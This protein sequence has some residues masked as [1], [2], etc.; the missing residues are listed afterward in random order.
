MTVRVVIGTILVAVTM[1][2]TSF[3]LLSEPARMADFDAGY[4][5][6][7]IEA[8]AA[9]FASSCS[10]CHG[11][12]GQGIDGVAPALNARDLLDDTQGTPLRLKEIGWSGT[13]RDYI[14]G[15]ISSGRPRASAAFSTY[16]RRMP[17][18]SQDF[19]GP[20]RQD[21]IEYVTDFVMNW[22]ATAML[23]SLATP[24][25]NPNAPGTD[26]TVELPTGDAANGEL[27]FNGK[28]ATVYPCSACHKLD[29]TV[30]VGPSL[31]G[32]ATTAATR[33]DGYD[34]AKY[35]HESIVS[36]SKFVVEGFTDGIMPPTFAQ[37]MTKQDLADIIA[38]LLTQK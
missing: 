38:F 32:I 33:K 10:T 8:G 9:I 24:T 7:S 25:P 31:K 28:G 11:D 34:A 15:T 35:I 18:W 22:K 2:I 6:R 12:N 5:G 13:V 21:Q 3:V 29:G 16:A 19:G 17:T 30:G 4:K 20:L 37:Q 27:L 23:Q 1:F 36:P 14:K 26:L